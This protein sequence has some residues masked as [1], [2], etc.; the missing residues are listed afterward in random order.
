[1][2]RYS[3]PDFVPSDLLS[4]D[5]RIT[6][7]WEERSA[8]L[9]AR[10]YVLCQRD[11]PGCAVV[12]KVA[13]GTAP[14]KLD[15]D[16]EYGFP[17]ESTRSNRTV[18]MTVATRATDDRLVYIK[19]VDSN[20][21]RYDC[22][23][24]KNIKLLHSGSLRVSSASHCTPVFDLFTHGEDTFAVTPVLT[25]LPRDAFPRVD[26]VL[27]FINQVLPGVH[28]MHSQ[29]I[30]HRDCSFHNIRTD[31]A[32]G[33]LCRLH[34]LHVDQTRNTP[35]DTATSL[36]LLSATAFARDQPLRY[37]INDLT[38]SMEHDHGPIERR[39]A[40]ICSRN[41]GAPEY[42]ESAGGYNP[43]LLD[44]WLIGSTFLEEFLDK[45]SNLEFC[46]ELVE[47]MT[48]TVPPL[49][50]DASECVK[51]WFCILQRLPMSVRTSRLRKRS[52]ADIR[53]QSFRPPREEF[54]SRFAKK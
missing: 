9:K 39:A 18:I 13:N 2:S 12:Q 4:E 52:T 50:P 35:E 30:A 28:F 24:F 23:E 17:Q 44:I 3:E 22:W 42:D 49:R 14:V 7:D 1:M 25:V 38:H 20:T 6:F 54:V 43:F 11:C 27:Q 48:H 37:Y 31:A 26:D 46:R 40:G 32:S 45:Y 21:R 19:K 8:M 16:S 33:Y 47:S 15:G 53:Y 34:Q 41:Q 5:E 36:P 29:R 10:G 51:E